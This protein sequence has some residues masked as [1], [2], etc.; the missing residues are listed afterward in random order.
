MQPP[1]NTDSTKPQASRGDRFVAR[2]I[3]GLFDLGV[4][5]IASM[6]SAFI[7]LSMDQGASRDEALGLGLIACFPLLLVIKAVLLHRRS[8][9]VGKIVMGL[10]IVRT[11][12]GRANVARTLL[13]RAFPFFVFSVLTSN[14]AGFLNAVFIFGSER[15]CLH[16][17]VAGTKVIC[18]KQSG[19]QV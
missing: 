8:Q 13:L 14:F 12:G 4:C 7:V 2:I 11:D 19:R 16:D 18:V 9:T 15:K 5:L 10:R 1:E 17:Y 6:T 3:D